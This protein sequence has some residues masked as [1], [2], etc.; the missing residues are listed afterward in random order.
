[1]AGP[2]YPTIPAEPATAS[3][4][5]MALAALGVYAKAHATIED[6]GGGY[7]LDAVNQDVLLNDIQRLILD[8]SRL[9]K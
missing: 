7:I 8:V 1:M 4:A 9:N 2:I 6:G 5:L 3:E